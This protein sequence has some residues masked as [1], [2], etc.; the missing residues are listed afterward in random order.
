MTPAGHRGAPYAAAL[1]L[2]AAITVATATWAGLGP[3]AGTTRSAR[4]A[5]SLAATATV[6]A[7]VLGGSLLGTDG[8][9]TI[10]FMGSDKRC[11]A[12]HSPLGAERC[13]SLAPKVAAASA[14]G[15]PASALYPYI[16]S[17]AADAKLNAPRNAAGT[18]RTDV[19]AALASLVHQPTWLRVEAERAVSRAMGGS[20]SM[21]LAAHAVLHGDILD[22]HAAWGN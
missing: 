17:S 10:L 3:L 8:R 2:L 20:C 7:S 22:L 4:A 5:E 16:W 14:D 19:I 9:Y 11:R 1:A 13:S 15:S 18:E 12:I 6:P 21:P